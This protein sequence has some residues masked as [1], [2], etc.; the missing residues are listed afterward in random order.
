MHARADE[1]MV[2]LVKFAPESDQLREMVM[3]TIRRRSAGNDG[4]GLR[5]NRDRWPFMVAAGVF[6]EL[7]SRNS[8]LLREV[9]E[10]FDKSPHN[11]TAASALA[12]ATLR[13]PDAAIDR[14]LR[15][16]AAGVE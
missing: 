12:E 10:V 9:T 7:F 8:A 5:T 2:A 4:G 13:R 16:K 14:L 1:H 3:D 15:A 6:A 11:A